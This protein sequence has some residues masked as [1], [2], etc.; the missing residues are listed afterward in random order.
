M[1]VQSF[2]QDESQRGDRRYDLGSSASCP[3]LLDTG[4]WFCPN[5]T[6]TAIRA[7]WVTARAVKEVTVSYKTEF[8]FSPTDR[9]ALLPLSVLS[10]SLSVDDA[11]TGRDGA[12]TAG[13]A[14]YSTDQSG[15]FGKTLSTLS[16]T[17][18]SCFI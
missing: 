17:F 4:F 8:F 11:S 12:G 7:Y 5:P 10:L 15:K 18:I 16:L 2:E 3:M 14:E 6:P 9:N 13:D 1:A